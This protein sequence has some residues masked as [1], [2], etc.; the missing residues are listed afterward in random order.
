MVT[1]DWPVVEAV[2]L[3]V[4]VPVE[5]AEVDAVVAGVVEG[6]AGVVDGALGVVDGA[7]GVVVAMT[8]P[9]FGW[10]HADVTV[11]VDVPLVTVLV[12]PLPGA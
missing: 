7:A 11:T 2:V 8:L 3:P 4:D 5:D 12:H 9:R 10:T 1:E 6:A